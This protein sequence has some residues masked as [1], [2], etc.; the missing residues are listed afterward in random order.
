MKMILQ[1][2][3]YVII[4]GLMLALLR[5]FDWDVIALVQWIADF[6]MNIVNAIAD[7]FSRNQTFNEVV[8]R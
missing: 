6:V 7:S 8:K 1:I 4:A 2:V 3:G 5:A